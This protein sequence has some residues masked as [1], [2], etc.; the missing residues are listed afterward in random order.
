MFIEDA[1]LL[2]AYKPVAS[3]CKAPSI[4]RL[5]RPPPVNRASSELEALMSKYM[6]TD[7]SLCEFN[8]FCYIY[9]ESLYNLLRN[10]MIDLKKKISSPIALQKSLTAAKSNAQDIKILHT[11]VGYREPLLLGRLRG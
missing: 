5:R 11:S 7:K 1:F 2:R 6:G 9:T 4:D 8:V 10:E 3:I